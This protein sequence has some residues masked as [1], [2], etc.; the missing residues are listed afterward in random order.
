MYLLVLIIMDLIIIMGSLLLTKDS[1][2]ERENRAA[3]FGAAG[4]SGHLVLLWFL[5]SEPATHF[6]VS[7]Y[8]GIVFFILVLFMIPGQRNNKALKGTQGYIVGDVERVDER[9]ISFSRI[10]LRPGSKEYEEYYNAHPESKALDDGIRAVGFLNNPNGIDRNPSN[11]AMMKTSFSLPPFLAP[12]ADAQPSPEIPKIEIEA[13]EASGIIKNFTLHL[14]ASSVG[15]CKVNQKWVYSK[16]GEIHFN[17]WEDWGTDVQKLPEYAVVF[18]TEMSYEHVMAAPHTPTIAESATQYAKGA[19]ISTML[20][21]WF[22]NMGYTGIAEH[23]RNYDLITPPLAVDAGLGE[24]G[25]NGYLITPEHGARVRVFA[26]LTDMP[27]VTDKP[28]SVGVEE[29][30]KL[31]KKCA[32]TCPSRSIP[33]GEMTVNNGVE[34]WKLDADSCVEY[35]SHIATDCAICMAVCGFSRPNSLTHNIVRWFIKKSPI[36]RRVFPIMDDI[37]Y[38]AKWRPR[39]VPNWLEYKKK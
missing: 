8:F 21:H 39:N 9:D 24:T 11:L 32:T 31:C 25:R 3:Y 26:T 18:C 4:T 27:L 34:K 23:N 30:C 15:I 14:G 17:N 7:I 22:K 2:I 37:L 28:I 36:A 20:A 19:F 1:I 13:G 38:G 10:K 33:D 5:L 12:H 6:F 29:Y 16:H 35:W